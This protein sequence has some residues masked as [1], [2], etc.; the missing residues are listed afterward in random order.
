MFEKMERD[1]CNTEGWRVV[2]ARLADVGTHG[3]RI[4]VEISHNAI[5]GRNFHHIDVWCDML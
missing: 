5:P 2:D 3:V 4:L 1:R